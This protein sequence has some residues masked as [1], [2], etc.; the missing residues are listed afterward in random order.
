MIVDILSSASFY[1]SVNPHFKTAFNFLK[2][3]DLKA[4]PSGK[5]SI[6]GEAVFAAVSEYETKLPEEAKFEIHRRYI[7]IQFL[8]E[9]VENIGV[10]KASDC[11]VTEDYYAEKDLAFVKP[12]TVYV[13]TVSIHDDVFAILFPHDAHQP[14]VMRDQKAN[15]KKVVIKVAVI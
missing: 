5:H 1:E 11:V 10:C 12:N 14:C 8:I 4:L 2:T 7:D 9:G 15:V 13:D 6:D 3:V